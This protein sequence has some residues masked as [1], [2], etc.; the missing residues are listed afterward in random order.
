ML[1]ETVWFHHDTGTLVVTDLLFCFSPTTRGVTAFVATLLGV[2][3]K[4]GMTRSM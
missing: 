3:G 4:L 2:N 1:T